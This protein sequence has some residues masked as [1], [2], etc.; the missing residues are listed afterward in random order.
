MARRAPSEFPGEFVEVD[1]ADPEATAGLAESLAARG[2]VLGIVNNIGLTA[3]EKFGEVAWD[4]FARVADL[5]LRPALQLTQALLPAMRAAKFGRIV[6]VTSLVTRGLA[7]RSS[8]AAA[9]SS[10]DSLTRSSLRQRASPPTPLPPARPKPNFSAKTAR[11]AA[12]AKNASCRSSRWAALASPT[13]LRLRL[14]F[15][16]RTMRGS[17]PVSRYSSMAVQACRWPSKYCRTAICNAGKTSLS[18]HGL[19]AIHPVLRHDG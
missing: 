9:K 13:K 15:W 18:N 7:W 1:L 12:E 10:L 11:R 19:R 4:D 6:N 8:Y 3:H 2:D 5:N 16:H 17:L 14:P